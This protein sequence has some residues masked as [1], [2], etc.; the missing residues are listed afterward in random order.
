[1]T[2]N[3]TDDLSIIQVPAA[4]LPGS[5]V[6][7]RLE[8]VVLE[9]LIVSRARLWKC[10]FTANNMLEDHVRDRE[11]QLRVYMSIETGFLVH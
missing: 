8:V 10:C 5:P 7:V 9:M 11:E 3:V 1:M 6:L 4:G 2:G